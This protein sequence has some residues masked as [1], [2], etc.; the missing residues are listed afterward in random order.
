[1]AL[2]I[3]GELNDINDIRDEVESVLQPDGEVVGCSCGGEELNIVG[4]GALIKAK[5]V[6][7]V[8][9]QATESVVQWNLKVGNIRIHL[10]CPGR[11]Q[12][13]LSAQPARCGTS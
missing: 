2:L 3:D 5:A 9:L 13:S 6:L 12:C 1:M 10:R 8:V 11:R 4:V 7:V